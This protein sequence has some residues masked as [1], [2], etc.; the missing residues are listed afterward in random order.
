MLEK[1]WEASYPVKNPEHI[2]TRT[3]LPPLPFQASYEEDEE[4]NFFWLISH[5]YQRIW[6]EEQKKWETMTYQ[7]KEQQSKFM[8]KSVNPRLRPR[9]YATPPPIEFKIKRYLKNIL[10][11]LLYTRKYTRYLFVFEMKCDMVLFK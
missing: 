1:K 2:N 3:K 5:E 7:S 4:V 11:F 9:R 8:R 6:L 10:Y